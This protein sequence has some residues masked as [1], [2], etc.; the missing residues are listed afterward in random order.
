MNLLFFNRLPANWSITQQKNF[1][2]IKK[3]LSG[4]KECDW[5]YRMWKNR[6]NTFFSRIKTEEWMG[7]QVEEI[8]KSYIACEHMM[9][10]IISV[11][12]SDSGTNLGWWSWI[13]DT[14][15]RL[16][17]HWWNILSITA[18]CSC[19]KLL[20]RPKKSPFSNNSHWSLNYTVRTLTYIF[21]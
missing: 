20:T 14:L 21:K 16:H 10:I 4:H 19:G 13:W 7:K 2:L 9:D 17:S 6:P 18:S 1:R 12:L 3:K 15:L 8:V 11:W 5:S